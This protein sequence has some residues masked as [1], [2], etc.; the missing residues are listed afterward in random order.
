MC[1][2]S[3]RGGTRC[4]QSARG[5]FSSRICAA[6]R[7]CP[8]RGALRARG[9]SGVGLR[10]QG[11]GFGRR[12]RCV[13]APPQEQRARRGTG[14]LLIP[15]TQPPYP[16]DTAP[17]SQPTQPRA[18]GRQVRETAG[19]VRGGDRT[20]SPPP[21]PCCCSYAWPYGRRG[22]TERPRPRARRAPQPL[23]CQ[24][25]QSPRPAAPVRVQV[26]VQVRGTREGRSSKTLQ[27]RNIFT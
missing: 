23:L 7:S 8:G 19:R 6:G 24:W 2:F 17:L 13:P 11:S 4:V 3:T 26:W 25:L 27:R 22:A 20:S 21:S 15:T 14:L 9:A 5:P 16:N 12:A 1:P 18:A 10:A